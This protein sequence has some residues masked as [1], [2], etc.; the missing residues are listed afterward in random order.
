MGFLGR[1][2]QFIRALIC[3]WRGHDEQEYPGAGWDPVD[4]RPGRILRVPTPNV[5]E[6]RQPLVLPKGL[7]E[8]M[9]YEMRLKYLVHLVN[10]PIVVHRYYCARC[11]EAWS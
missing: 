7:V 4:L 10:P 11:G 6:H 8:L 5:I 3:E 2:L 1:L 9:P